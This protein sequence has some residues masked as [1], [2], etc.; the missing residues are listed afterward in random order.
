[1]KLGLNQP[2][3]GNGVI[4]TGQLESGL[5]GISAS[6]KSNVPEAMEVDKNFILIC[7]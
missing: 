2:K 3:W 7:V 5:Q 6:S 1:M 4:P